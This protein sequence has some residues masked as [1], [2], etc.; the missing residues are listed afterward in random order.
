MKE[1]GRRREVAV[2]VEIV[3]RKEEDVA[4]PV[5]SDGGG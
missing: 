1:G 5:K 3:R 4:R 2:A